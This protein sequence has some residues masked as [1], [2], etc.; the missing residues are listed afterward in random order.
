MEK[1]YICSFI[2]KDPSNVKI[3]EKGFAKQKRPP[4]CSHATPHKARPIGC[5]EGYCMISHVQA[6]C[7]PVEEENQIES[8]W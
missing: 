3:C 7:V 2:K 6:E 5:G 8:I 1:M 4:N